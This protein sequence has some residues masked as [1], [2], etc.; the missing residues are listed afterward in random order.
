MVEAP[1]GK[2][3]LAIHLKPLLAYIC[4]TLLAKARPTVC[5]VNLLT[6]SS[7][8]ALPYLLWEKGLDSLGHVSSSERSAN[9]CQ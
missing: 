1:E 9:S 5:Q 4:Y 7:K 2:L 6:L 8:C 3:G